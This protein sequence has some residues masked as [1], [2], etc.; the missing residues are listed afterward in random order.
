MFSFLLGL[1]LSMVLPDHILTYVKP[2]AELPDCFPKWLQYFIFLPVVYE[3]F[4]FS[5]SS[6][7]LVIFHFLSYSHASGFEVVSP[8]GFDV[9]FPKRARMPLQ[10]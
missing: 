8:C 2:L 7:T 1:Y 3:G 6:A 10:H 9:H 5:T 4:N